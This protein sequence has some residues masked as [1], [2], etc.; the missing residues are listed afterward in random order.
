MRD[1]GFYSNTADPRPR[2]K[3]ANGGAEALSDAEIV[4]LLIGSGHRGRNV[5]AISEAVSDLLS[6]GP[7]PPDL[8]ELTAV[9]GVG[10][11][12]ASRL[13]AAFELGRRV[14][15][16]RGTRVRTPE[17]VFTV[18]RHLGDRN[19]EHFVSLTLNGAHELI[20]WV[21]VSIGLVNRTV[22]HPREVFAPA[23]EDRTAAI[24]VAHNHP[25]GN[26]EP[27]RDD[28]EVTERL[29]ESGELLGVRLLDHVVFSS[30][31]FSS[32]LDLGKIV[33]SA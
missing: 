25:S 14:F 30:H 13:C 31:R 10:C 22:I 24:V 3:L 16:P 12:I 29:F 4:S 8:A 11:A 28:E 26:V 21:L 2:E 27:S 32:F 33:G 1:A 20:R 18:V 7:S 6:I 17:D 23:L 19:Q 9:A 15:V 5:H